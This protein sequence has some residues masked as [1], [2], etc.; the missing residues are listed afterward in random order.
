MCVYGLY[1]HKVIYEASGFCFK[2]KDLLSLS[3]LEIMSASSS[4]YVRDMF[5]G[6]TE[7]MREGTSVA[8]TRP[9]AT[10]ATAAT[11]SASPSPKGT[12]ST[13]LSEN[14]TAAAVAAVAATETVTSQFQ[15]QLA[16]LMTR[17]NAAHPQFV[18]CL[19]P[20]SKKEA[21]KVEPEMILDQ[22]RC[23]G[24]AAADVC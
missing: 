3:M 2:N 6:H 12:C 23:S 19:N 5:K 22:L 13:L 20:N 4:A 18:R 24:R 10:A 21:Y 11:A 1:K 9:A 14:V 17:I 8:N 16:T 7:R 15:R